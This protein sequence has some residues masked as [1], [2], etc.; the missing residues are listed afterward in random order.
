MRV[1]YLLIGFLF[2]Y[3]LSGQNLSNLC[4]YCT[5]DP[6][7]EIPKISSCND[8]VKDSIVDYY[9]SKTNL[10]FDFHNSM[11]EFRKQSFVS[12]FANYR[13]KQFQGNKKK[14]F[15][16]DGDLNLPI[17]L[18]GPNCNT[19]MHTIQAIPR[20][21]FRMFQSDP[22]ITYGIFVE[23]STP[24]RTP[25][26]MPGAAWYFT[27]HNWW[28]IDGES[29]ESKFH[30]KYFGIYAYHHSNGQ[31]GD[32]LITDLQGNLIVNQY[33]G[34]FGEQLVF[35]F[36]FGGKFTL[37]G[38]DVDFF[39]SPCDSLSRKIG[40]TQGIEVSSEKKINWNISLEVRPNIW[41]NKDFDNYDIYGKS[42]IRGNITYSNFK[43]IMN[44]LYNGSKW[45]LFSNEIPFEQFR[46]HLEFAY[47]LDTNL[48]T[49]TDLRNLQSTSFFNPSRRLN[50][51]YTINWIP[52]GAKNLG[53]YLQFSYIGSDEYNIYFQ[54]SYL[55]A[56]FGFSFA[57]F[58][59]PN[60][61]DLLSLLN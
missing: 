27:K 28:T 42:R 21:K 53:L 55:S 16:L 17:G 39:E 1:F 48:K 8:S 57:F 38:D 25:S 7:N 36:I 34:N 33:N 45:C 2:S 13:I 4:I 9:V 14:P 5:D 40:K 46:Q 19:W 26:A 20:F 11:K 22:D 29:T 35:D 30:D 32:E 59:Q 58:N 10:H 15:A 51:I 12:P 41:T 54:D 60:K 18:R 49:G 23:E 47:I 43:T 24:V 61:S 31:D 52:T 3:S 56:N 50:L 37:V 44:F 6:C